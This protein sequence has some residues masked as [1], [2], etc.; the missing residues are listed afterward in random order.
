MEKL[1]TSTDS[2]IPSDLFNAV[3]L[4]AQESHDHPTR[5][6]AGRIKDGIADKKDLEI[7]AIRV[8]KQIKI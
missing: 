8:K 6:L 7:L 2:N 4:A 3:I 5:I 1:Q